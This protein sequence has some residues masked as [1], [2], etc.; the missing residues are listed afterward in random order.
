M[1]YFRKIISLLQETGKHYTA[2][3]GSM[4]AAA[5]AYYTMFSL[6]PLLIISIALAEQFLSDTNVQLMLISRIRV[7]AGTEVSEFVRTMVQG[8]GEGT[9]G[10]VATIVSVGIIIFGASNVF[11]QLKRALNTVWGVDIEEEQGVINFLQL[12]LV[13]FGLVLL[14]GVLLIT[15]IT[16]NAL[17]GIVNALIAG[18]LPGTSGFSFVFEYAIPFVMTVTLFALLYKILPD[19]DV[20]WRDV[21]LGAVVTT[22]LAGFVLV[23]LRIYLSVSSF[24]AAYGAAGSL[25]VLLFLVYYGAQIFLLGAEFTQVYSRRYGSRARFVVVGEEEEE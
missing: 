22:V 9:S 4:L 19:V 1:E 8:F 5:L 18:F 11:R 6:A 23:A 7:L 16:M 13:S 21:W 14:I 2:D 12:N 17:A 25:V 24:G 20:S 3:R 15:A 10:W